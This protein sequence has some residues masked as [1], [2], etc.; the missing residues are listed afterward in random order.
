MRPNKL[1]EL[2]NAGQPSVGTHVLTPW[3][4]MIEIV[5]H[6]KAFDYIEWVGEYSPFSLDL[7]DNIG[8]ALDLFP[9]MSSMTKVEE[10]TR[11]FIAQHAIDSGIQNV[12]FTDIRT[13]EDARECV[14]IVRSEHPEAGGIHGACMRRNV[15]YVLESGRPTW[16]QAMND[17][18]VALMIEH[19]GALAR[20]GVQPGEDD[21]PVLF[22]D[23]RS[24][25][26]A[27]DLEASWRQALGDIGAAAG[28]VRG[29]A[30]GDEAQHHEERD[31]TEHRDDGARER[32]FQS[33]RPSSGCIRH[34]PQ[35]AG[36]RRRSRERL[37]LVGVKS[38]TRWGAAGRP[39]F[40]RVART[41]PMVHAS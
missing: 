26:H 34:R 29:D 11:G 19:Q 18:V 1:R 15:G 9:N 16:V 22:D 10:Q 3:P 28:D 20:G 2:L 12:L 35:S 7:M 39:P 27:G 25:L 8:R 33:D 4:G 13:A 14:Q 17:V 30:P 23:A 21:R 5:G 37:R 31:A 38:F 24:A 40:R 32:R 41:C 36:D 6:S